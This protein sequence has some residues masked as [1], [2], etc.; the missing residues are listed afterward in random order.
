MVSQILRRLSYRSMKIYGNLSKALFHIF[1]VFAPTYRKTMPKFSPAAKEGYAKK[2]IPRII[3]QT[4]YTQRVSLQVYMCYL[5]NRFRSP[6]FEYRFCSDDDCDAFVATNFPGR[7]YDAYQR[8]QI[9]AARAD[10]WR[11]LVLL[12]NGGFYL[13]ID[14]NFTANPESLLKNDPG[15]I[16]IAMKNGEITNYFL[17]SEPDN[18]ILKNVCDKIVENIEKDVIKN[19]Y[20]LTGPTVLDQEARIAGAQITFYKEAC[21]QG[22]FIN[23]FGQYVDKPNGAWTTAQKEIPIVKAKH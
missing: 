15:Y 23:K 18:A 16:F 6:S 2:R 19:V 9:G 4:N 10:F 20:D 7:V 17:A 12:K 5:F 11:I 22:Q 21:V 1:L 14:A 13:D 3:W 8:L